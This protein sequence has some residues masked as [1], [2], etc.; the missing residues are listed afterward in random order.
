[1]I[2]EGTIAISRGRR[3]HGIYSGLLDAEKFVE[4]EVSFDSFP[5][6][7]PFPSSFRY[8]GSVLEMVISQKVIS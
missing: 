3:P 8:I 6:S 1:M 5:L 4:T 2:H 7:S